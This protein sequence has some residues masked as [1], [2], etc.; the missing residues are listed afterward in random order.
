MGLASAAAV[1][2]GLIAAG[3][4]PEYACRR[5]GA[6]HAV[7]TPAPRSATSR[8]CRR[9]PH[10]PATV[11]PCSSSGRWSPAPTPGASR[12]PVLLSAWRSPH[13]LAPAAEAE[14][15]RPGGRHRQPARGRRGRLSHGRRHIGRPV[16]NRLPWRRTAPAAS[17]L[18]A[19]A[20]ADDVGAVGAYVAPVDLAADGEI[21]PGN[22]REAIRQ[23]GPT[24]DLP[25]TFGI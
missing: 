2:D 1:R 8:T 22:L 4:D 5:S 10:K 19:A 11:R 18:L 9:S 6:R 20:A 3:R 12:S 16:S 17:E 23:A 24:I 7:P 13:D 14:D 25:V 21:R 15:H